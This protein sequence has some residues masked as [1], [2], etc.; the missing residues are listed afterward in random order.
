MAAEA[1]TAIAVYS[2]GVPVYGCRGLRRAPVEERIEYG[3]E[4]MEDLEEMDVP[5]D[6]G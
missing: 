1:A 5:V 2:D 3:R 4:G 6:G